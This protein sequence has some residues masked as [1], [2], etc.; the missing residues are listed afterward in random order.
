MDFVKNIIWYYSAE[1]RQGYLVGSISGIVLVTAAI[2]LWMVAAPST[3]L[4]GLAIMILLGGLIFLFGGYF[5]GR[6]A[7]K[8]KT[9]KVEQY[10]KYQ[11]AFIN[12]EYDKVEKIHKQWMPIRVFWSLFLVVGISLLLF[13]T[14]AFWVGIALGALIVGTLG[15]IEEV[16]SFQHNEKY[17]KE[18]T[19]EKSRLDQ[20]TAFLN[21]KF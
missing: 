10:N 9:E 6:G 8:S 2:I 3:I 19:K 7:Q 14:S 17:R 1:T 12:E 4:K 15:H 21:Y 5:A 13:T 20:S 16:I 11:K 18:V